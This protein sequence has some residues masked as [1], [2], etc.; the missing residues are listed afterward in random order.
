MVVPE[1]KPADDI[2]EEM[3]TT[4][5]HFAVVIDEYGGTAGI[6]TLDDLL[7]AIVG[8]I[9]EWPF[10]DDPADADGA[11]ERPAALEPD[12]SIVME[13]LTRLEEWEEAT[14]VRLAQE[15]RAQAETIGGA[16]MY[17]LGRIPTVGDEITINGRTVR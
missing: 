14:G 5:R 10:A 15:D 16:I 4:G 2:L 1:I 13:G 7:E 11:S 6:L 12:G 8:P 9:R 3:R 17:R